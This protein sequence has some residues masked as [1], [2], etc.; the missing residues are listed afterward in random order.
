MKERPL[1][2]REFENSDSLSLRVIRAA[3]DGQNPTHVDNSTK[4]EKEEEDEQ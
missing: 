2:A 4:R 1:P 3:Q